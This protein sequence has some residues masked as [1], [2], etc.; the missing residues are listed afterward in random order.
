MRNLLAILLAVMMFV[1]L[2]ACGDEKGDAESSIPVKTQEPETAAIQ[3]T[4]DVASSNNIDERVED[5][6]SQLYG[7]WNLYSMEIDGVTFTVDELKALGEEEASE[8]LLVIKEGGMA[9]LYSGGS[10]QMIDWEETAEGIKLG[11]QECAIVDEKICMQ[12][13]GVTMYLTRISDSQAIPNQDNGIEDSSS[14]DL[15]DG[16][17]PEFKEAMDSY[18]AFYDEYCDFMQE[19]AADPTDMSLLSEYSDLVSQAADMDEKFAEWEDD[20]M[21]D[22]ELEYYL[23]VSGRIVQRLAEVAG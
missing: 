6:M 3:E 21:N 9:W 2:T 14:A 12:V 23:E 1:T 13:N 22:A 15:I 8:F 4:D 17:R 11:I 5:N 16:M 20:D 18:E 10:G 19:F 7:T